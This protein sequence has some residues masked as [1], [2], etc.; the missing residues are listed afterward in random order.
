MTSIDRAYCGLQPAHR[1]DARGP[2]WRCGS[3]WWERLVV[4][5]LELRKAITAATRAQTWARARWPS[6]PSWVARPDPG[7][8]AQSTRD[9]DRRITR[10]LWIR[11][12]ASLRHRGRVL[13]QPV[14]NRLRASKSRVCQP[15]PSAAGDR[16]CPLTL[17]LTCTAWLVIW[18]LLSPP[19]PRIGG[20]RRGFPRLK[21]CP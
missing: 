10:G 5:R 8:T 15:A 13:V 1:C 18:S 11:R 9:L 19:T 12:L 6:R 21:I 3:R 7:S 14:R 17:A 2:A 20:R 4:R 16:R